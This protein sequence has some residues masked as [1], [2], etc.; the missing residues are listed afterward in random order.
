MDNNLFLKGA[1][2]KIVN[3]CESKE[4]NS[5]G[6]EPRWNHSKVCASTKCSRPVTT[7]MS[8]WSYHRLRGVYVSS[9]VQIV[10]VL[11]IDI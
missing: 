10:L 4:F 6:I 5:T 8:Q 3:V 9:I 1:Q 2:T 7:V 11:P